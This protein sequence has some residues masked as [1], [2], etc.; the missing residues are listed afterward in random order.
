MEVILEIILNVFLIGFFAFIV[1]M[2][3]AWA[4]DTSNQLSHLKLMLDDLKLQ[5]YELQRVTHIHPRPRRNI[6]E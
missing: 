1:I 3:F 6:F 2:I 5:L 4:M